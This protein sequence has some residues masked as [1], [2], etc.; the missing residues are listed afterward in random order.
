MKFSQ[1][2]VPQEN[3]RGNSRFCEIFEARKLRKRQRNLQKGGVIACDSIQMPARRDKAREAEKVYRPPD[4]CDFFTVFP[5][6]L[7][8]V[9]MKFTNIVLVGD[10]NCNL[11]KNSHGELPHDGNRLTRIFQQFSMSNVIE[12]PTRVT[13]HSKT[14]IDL[15]V[16]TRKDL[17]KLR[18]T[19]PLGISDH[20]MIYERSKSPTKNNKGKKFQQIR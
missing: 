3:K 12:G 9:W 17:V 20:D 6:S 8:K 10:F 18:G 5:R 19:C 11:L 15:I 4:N 7:E 14:L 16:S 1:D 2:G 13:S